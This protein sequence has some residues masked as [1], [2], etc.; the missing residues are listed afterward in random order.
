MFVVITPGLMGV[1]SFQLTLQLN[2]FNTSCVF[3][4]LLQLLYRH[5]RIF[6]GSHIV[7]TSLCGDGYNSGYYN[8]VRG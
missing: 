8:R 4:H 7:A 3:V 2:L 5:I 1:P 6:V